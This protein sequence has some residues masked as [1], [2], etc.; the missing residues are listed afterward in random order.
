MTLGKPSPPQP[1]DPIETARG[2][3][4]TNVSTAIANANLNNVNQITPD[5]S[6]TFDQTG[7]FQQF[8]PTINETFDI[9]TFTA[10][11]TLS[12]NAQAIKDQTDKAQLNLAGLASD[13]SSR[14]GDLLGTNVDLSNEAVESRLFELGS[15]RLNPLFDEREEATRTRLA[16]QGIQAGSVAHDRA[17]RGDSQARN[18]AFNELLL[19]GRGQSVQE[20]LTKRNQPINEISALL[21]GSQVSQPNFIN[22]GQGKIPTTD[23]AGIVN[24]NYNQR[25][26]AFNSQQGSPLGGIASSIIGGLFGLSDERTKK[27]IKKVGEIEGQ[28]LYRFNYKDEPDSTPKHIGLMA[29]EV[30]KTRPDAVKS[31]FGIKIVDYEKALEERHA[32]A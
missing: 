2:A 7:T 30:E 23:F 26:N 29:Q 15:N 22:A 27:N 5:G 14:V 1:P 31:L 21:S 4:G 12:P 9:P 13:Q 3:T 10:T 6:L 20:Q 19:R 25:L 8:D 11:Q 17:T 16:N 32:A 24:E 28:N 18:D